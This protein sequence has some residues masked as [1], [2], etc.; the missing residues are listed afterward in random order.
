MRSADRGRAEDGGRSVQLTRLGQ[1][2]WPELG[3]VKAD[4]VD[5][6]GRIAPVLVPHLRGRPFTMKRHF[7]GPRSPFA[8]VKD[9]PPELPDWIGVSPQPAK[10]RRGE[11]VRYPLVEDELAL[12]WMIEFGCIDLHVWTSRGDRPDR[13][14]VVL[15]DL[16]P[17]SVAFADVARAALL[18]RGTLDVL[19][20]DSYPMTTGGEGMHVRVPIAR[21]HTY[22]DVRSFANVVARAVAASSKGLVTLER[23]LAQ[24]R[25]VFVDT[26]MNGHGQQVVAPYSLR[27]LPQAAV[28]TPLR[29]E[30]VDEGLD[31][32]RFRIA[33]VAVRAGREDV[34]AP[35]LE[36][37]QRLG[38]ALARIVS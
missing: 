10:S 21:R 29:W 2:W 30:E 4:V 26:K 25:G 34:A 3:I 27:P 28:A 13:P 8:W 22:E 31:P 7:N 33:E 16:D 24:R 18:L 9:A 23:S 20:L 17:A 12:L 1:L 35:L 5:Y 15:F 19:G 14:D 36:G 37:R 6:Y 11:I 38:P 32:A